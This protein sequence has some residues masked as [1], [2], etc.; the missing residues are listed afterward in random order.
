MWVNAFIYMVLGRLIYFLVPSKQVFGIPGI[1]I[2][3]VFVW[4]DVVS[5][6][7]QVASGVMIQPGGDVKTIMLGIHIYMGGIGFQ[8][9]CIILFTTI[10]VSLHLSLLRL[11]RSKNIL[12]VKPSVWCR[13]VYV[14]YAVLA[15]ITIRIIFRMVEF[16]SGLDPQRNPIPYHEAYFMAL[17]ALPMTVAVLALNVVHPGKILQNEGSEFPKWK[18]WKEKRAEKKARKCEKRARKSGILLRDGNAVHLV[19]VCVFE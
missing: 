6:L 5:F 8:E 10:V 19:N 7:T 12:P 11:E 18:S 2:A 17:D 16:A 15:L 9:A 13:S 4:L 1:K 14:V 3:R